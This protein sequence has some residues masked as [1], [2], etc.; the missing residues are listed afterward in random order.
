MDFGQRINEATNTKNTSYNTYNQYQQQ[1]D[2]A[3]GTFDQELAKRQNFGDIYNNA[4]NQYM[5]TDEINKARGTFNEAR[6]AVDKI[7]ATI[8]NLPASIRQQ[9]GGTGLTEAQRQRALQHQMGAMQDTAD[10][11]SKNYANAS[12]DYNTLMSRALQEAQFA[13]TGQYQGQQDAINT[14]QNVWATLLGQRN[15]AYSQYQ[16]DRDA[17]AAQYGARDDW[18]LR[19]QAMELE[20]WKEQQANARAAAD[21]NAQFSLQKYLMDRQEQG[22]NAD[23]AFQR[24]LAKQERIG[25]QLASYNLSQKEYERQRNAL[26]EFNRGNDNFV[27]GYGKSIAK[28]GPLALFGKGWAW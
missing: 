3:K 10:H 16:G 1:A 14:L 25:Q 24:E 20:R 13:A 5:N 9:F 28:Y 15:T 22:K 27:S 11:Y 2:A 7:G 6:D 12:Q 4:R 17:L 26:P 21:R 23:R 18:N 8:N 19:Q